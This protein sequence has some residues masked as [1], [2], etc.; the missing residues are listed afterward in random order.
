MLSMRA[1]VTSLTAQAAGALPSGVPLAWPGVSLPTETLSEWVEL[2]C[3]SVNG[4]IQREQPP[5]QREVWVTL[6]V[7][8]RP[9]T[10]TMRAQELSELLRQ[11]FHQQVLS[12]VDSTTTPATAVGTVRL[13]EADVR[14]LTPG[15]AEEQRRPL[16][17]VVVLVRGLVQAL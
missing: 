11:A 1:I 6:N 3:D 17:Q 10:Q 2:W 5:E 12:I 9:G 14:D 7:F 15:H 13:R 8:V 16:H 4:V